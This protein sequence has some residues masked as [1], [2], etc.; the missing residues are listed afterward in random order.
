[1]VGA[2]VTSTPLLEDSSRGL[3][4]QWTFGVNRY[5]I[6]M[7]SFAVQKYMSTH[8]WLDHVST[9]AE[10]YVYD[11]SDPTIWILSERLVNYAFRPKRPS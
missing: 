8:R 5:Y 6:Y 1:M 3:Y 10:Y 2:T 11:R 9:H 7:L 4:D